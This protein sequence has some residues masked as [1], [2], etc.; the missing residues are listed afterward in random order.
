[1]LNSISGRVSV[2]MLRNGGTSL[3]A[4]QFQQT[5]D[6]EDEDDETKIYED[7]DDNDEHNYEWVCEGCVECGVWGYVKSECVK[8][9]CEVC[10]VLGCTKSEFC[11]CWFERVCVCVCVCVC[12]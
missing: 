3:T 7:M 12:V 2:D 11:D 1:M 5:E 9:D 8:S 6:D 4:P 10:V